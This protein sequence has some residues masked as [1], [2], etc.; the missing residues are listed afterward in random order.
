MEMSTIHMEK[1]IVAAAT[2]ESVL[3]LGQTQRTAERIARDI[4]DTMGSLLAY[5]INRSNGNTR[6]DFPDGG[7]IRFLTIRSELRGYS[8]DR[9]Y[10]PVD[11]EHDER[12]KERIWWTLQTSKTGE[13]TGYGHS[14]TRD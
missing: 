6:I 9:V 13:V 7:T 14:R 5:K 2:G 11:L 1:A 8:F 12:L 3:I 4:E 10:V